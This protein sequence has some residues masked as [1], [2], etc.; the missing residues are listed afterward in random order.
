MSKGK[1]QESLIATIA[2]ALVAVAAIA[3]VAVGIILMNKNNASDA[4]ESTQ[5]S[6]WEALVDECS[7][8]ANDLIQKNYTVLKLYTIEG[9]PY[10]TVYG[11]S[12]EDGYYSVNDA[13]Y[14][15]FS[16]IEELVKSVY[17][18]DEAER[19]LTRYP[20]KVE[21]GTK[22]VQVYK[23]HK[24]PSDGS[25]CL[26]IIEGFTPDADYSRDWSKC[27]VKVFPKSETEC[28]LTVFVDGYTEEEANSHPESVL[29]TK[30]VK[31]DGKWLM[32]TMLK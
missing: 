8:A 21:G 5:N 17:I 23:E 15:H 11:N 4:Q 19:I 2:T 28:E 29:T 13:N 20:V 3:A 24:D 25:D 26:G 32:S 16:Q 9:L 1:K 18:A 12:S 14:K 27:V 31:Q 22:D 30:M 10:K 6:I 7:E